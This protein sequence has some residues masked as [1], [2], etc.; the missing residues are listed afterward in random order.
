[1]KDRTLERGGINYIKIKS[2]IYEK[3]RKERL[4]NS[5]N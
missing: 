1:M 4:N 3:A 5:N 2:A